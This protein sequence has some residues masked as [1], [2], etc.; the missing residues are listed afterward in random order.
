MAGSAAGFSSLLAVEV[1][2]GFGFATGFFGAEGFFS[3]GVVVVVRF[4]LAAGAEMASVTRFVA[5][6]AE[7]RSV[8]DASA[9]AVDMV[10]LSFW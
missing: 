1:P 8:W 3:E 7:R 5:A 6:R 4:F 2:L 10:S 9:A